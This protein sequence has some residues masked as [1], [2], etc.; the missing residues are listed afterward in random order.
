[1]R[2]NRQIDQAPVQNL[3]CAKTQGFLA[4]EADGGHLKALL[5]GRSLAGIA[6]APPSA[7]AFT[8]T[9]QVKELDNDAIS[10]SP[11]T[12]PTETKSELG[13]ATKCQGRAREQMEPQL[14]TSALGALSLKHEPAGLDS[15]RWDDFD[16]CQ[17]GI[18]AA[19]AVHPLLDFESLTRRSSTSQGESGSIRPDEHPLL[20]FNPFTEP[21]TFPDHRAPS[22]GKDSV[23][24]RIRSIAPSDFASELDHHFSPARSA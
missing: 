3:D 17:P 6:E 10:P 1:M 18:E 2:L 15:D 4:A 5:I 19:F 16:Y 11:A 22:L 23:Q 24:H 7:E 9:G 20:S 14:P 21:T 13:S 12:R 8:G